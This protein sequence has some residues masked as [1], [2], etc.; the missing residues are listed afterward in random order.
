MMSM[1]SDEQAEAILPAE[2]NHPGTLSEGTEELLSCGSEWNRRG[3]S[4]SKNN[5][6]IS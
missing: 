5:V 3:V 4:V 2:T 1:S 6:S